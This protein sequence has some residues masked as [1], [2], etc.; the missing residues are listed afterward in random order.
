M[1]LILAV[2]LLA[3]AACAPA[4][5]GSGAFAPF[6]LNTTPNISVSAGQNWYFSKSYDLVGWRVTYVFDAITHD[7]LGRSYEVTS[8]PERLVWGNEPGYVL[9]D[10]GQSRLWCFTSTAGQGPMSFTVQ[11]RPIQLPAGWSLEVVEARGL[12]EC[13]SIDAILN[14]RPAFANVPGRYT[15]VYDFDTQYRFVY[16]LRVPAGTAPG[17]YPL[18]WQ[19]TD[20]REGKSV[21]EGVWITVQ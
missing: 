6:D 18:Q 9:S 1:R 13:R 10:L 3:L 4:P 20:L 12:L 5:L 17:Q 8:R 14:R 19:V 21:V 15:L 16:V 7:L 2:G 11:V